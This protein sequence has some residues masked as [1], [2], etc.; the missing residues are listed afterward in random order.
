MAT[1]AVL[2]NHTYQFK[3]NEVRLQEDVGPIGLELAGTIR[4]PLE[5]H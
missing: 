2:K 3:D 1:M 4:V 5:C